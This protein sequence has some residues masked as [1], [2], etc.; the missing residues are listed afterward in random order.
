MVKTY[1]NVRTGQITTNYNKG[2]LWYCN[3]YTVAVLKAGKVIHV[4][5][6]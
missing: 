5:R 2:M 1:L 6:K 3:G 4:L